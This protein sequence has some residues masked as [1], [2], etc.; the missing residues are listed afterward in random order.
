MRVSSTALPQ[1]IT[2]LSQ[3]RAQI[4][5]AGDNNNLTISFREHKR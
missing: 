3:P 1:L 5:A 2:Q 4:P